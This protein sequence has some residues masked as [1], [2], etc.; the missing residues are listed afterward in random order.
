METKSH[1]RAVMISA[2]TRKIEIS[3]IL[4]MPERESYSGMHERT[5]LTLYTL[6]LY[7]H[8]TVPVRLLLFSYMT[9]YARHLYCAI[10]SL[11]AAAS[12]KFPRVLQ[13]TPPPP[14]L[15]LIYP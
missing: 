8:A 4:Y 6:A 7:T 15:H 9:I 10:Y 5:P 13:L 11:C 12:I 2:H 3:R 14:I 1:A